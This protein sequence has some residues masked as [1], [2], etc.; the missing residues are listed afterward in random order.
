MVRP[1]VVVPVAF[2]AMLTALTGA[3]WAQPSGGNPHPATEIWGGITLVFPTLDTTYSTAFSPP[4][5][6]GEHSGSA[7]QVLSLGGT[8]GPGVEGGFGY[9]PHRVFGFQVLVGYHCTDLQGTNGPYHVALRYVARQ[10][11]DYQPREYR[12][13]QST[14]WPDTEG[15]LKELIVSVNGAARWTAGRHAGGSVSGG[16]SYFN[17]RGEIQP[18]G[19]SIFWLGGHSVLFGETY[20]LAAAVGPASTMGLNVGG[21]I[22]LRFSSKLAMVVDYRYFRA[23]SMSLPVTV[24]EI[25]NQDEVIRTTAVDEIQRQLDPQPIE[26]RPSFSRLLIGVKLRR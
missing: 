18:L 24:T 20:K 11:P 21:G 6:S 7:G 13:E 8:R 14:S 2:L 3:T 1:T 19:S 22:D 5:D 16:L 15:R 26:I 9:F 17:L 12:Y 25:V 4:F 23:G 10:P